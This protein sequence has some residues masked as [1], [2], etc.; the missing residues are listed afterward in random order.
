MQNKCLRVGMSLIV[1]GGV[2][3]FESVAG[4]LAFVESTRLIFNDSKR[5]V[6][7]PV[8]NDT[9]TTY[10]FHGLVYESQD[11]KLYEKSHNFRIVPEV[12]KLTPGFHQSFKVVQVR[13]TKLANQEQLYFLHGFFIPAHTPQGNHLIVDSPI[14]INLKMFVRP[15]EL[16]LNNAV[17][18][19]QGQL[20]FK[21]GPNRLEISNPTKYHLTFYSLSINDNEVSWSNSRRM[22]LPNSQESYVINNSGRD[23]CHIKYSMIDDNGRASKEQEIIVKFSN[24]GKQ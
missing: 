16:E 12:S 24:K 10:L 9:G 13:K 5:A 2:L 1:M 20:Q 15:E 21:C 14:A 18:K 8:R 4:E 6:S 11:G 19:V 7:L 22:L 3:S 23:A 17:S